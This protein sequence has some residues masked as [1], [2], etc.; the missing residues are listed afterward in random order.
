M[1]NGEGKCFGN[2]SEK[3]FVILFGDAMCT[4]ITNFSFEQTFMWARS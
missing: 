3:P 4:D 2:L 1:E